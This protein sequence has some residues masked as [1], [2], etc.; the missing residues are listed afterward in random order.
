MSG[1]YAAL[2][3]KRAMNALKWARRACE[4][5]DYDTC[6]L[7]AE[8]AVQLYLKSLLL[9]VLGEEVRGHHV[10]E[11]MGL[12]AAALMEQGMER[13]AHRVAEYVRRH[14]RELAELSDAHTRAVYGLVEYGEREAKLLLQIANQVIERLRELEE[15]LFAGAA[16]PA[17]EELEKGG[18]KSSQAGKE[19]LP[20]SKRVP[21]RRSGGGPVN[22]TERH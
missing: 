9:R 21:N 17:A 5:G 8:Y 18:A 16:A 22:H 19:A 20:E 4:E 14:R 10:R 1:E 7:E 11:L 12:L 15:V 2:L 13:L 6:A 3:R